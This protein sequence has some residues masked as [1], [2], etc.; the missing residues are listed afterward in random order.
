MT[1]R[2]TVPAPP[3]PTNA[4]QTGLIRELALLRKQRDQAQAEIRRLLT[5]NAF[6]EADMAILKAEIELMK[7]RYGDF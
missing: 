4:A 7:G 2:D 1:D 5:R 6:L 3:P